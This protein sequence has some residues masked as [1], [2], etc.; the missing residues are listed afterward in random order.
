VL[1]LYEGKVAE[2]YA[3]ISRTQQR[4]PNDEEMKF[5]RADIAFL[6]GSPDAEAALDTIAAA[7]VAPPLVSESARLRRG[8]FLERRDRQGGRALIDDAARV[9]Q[10]KIDGGD[11]SPMLR[12]EMAAA[13]VL[14]GD[15]AGAAQ[16]LDRAY[17]VGYRDYGV[18]DRMKH[19][20]DTQRVAARANGLLDIDALLAP[21]KTR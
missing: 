3:R 14:R 8:Y 21:A 12:V 4:L 17:D 19:D 5:T 2:S 18:L 10:G 13:A 16:W 11:R 9:A 20:V 7:D 1:E 6:A 15:D